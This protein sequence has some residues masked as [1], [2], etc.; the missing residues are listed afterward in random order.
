MTFG[1]PHRDSW[2]ESPFSEL[3]A[4][5]ISVS[6]YL[7]TRTQAARNFGTLGLVIIGLSAIQ[8]LLR[9]E[10]PSSYLCFALAALLVEGMNFYT[11]NF[12]KK[13]MSLK[14]IAALQQHITN[15]TGSDSS[16]VRK[17]LFSSDLAEA[18]ASSFVRTDRPWTLMKKLMFVSNYFEFAFEG[19]LIR[20]LYKTGISNAYKDAL[21][22]DVASHPFFWR[23]AFSNLLGSGELSKED[24]A[25]ISSRLDLSSKSS[26][27]I[28][29]ASILC[30]LQ[31]KVYRNCEGLLGR[32]GMGSE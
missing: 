29:L 32:E 16:L 5:S 12:K 13:R 6:D 22:V 20:S 31:Q 14:V 26:L 1:G 7:S 17:A 21:P 18:F 3:T 19:I 4:S 24:L 8:P 25:S 30:G 23:S 11:S 2:S 10:K 28:A 15:L 9:P 27:R